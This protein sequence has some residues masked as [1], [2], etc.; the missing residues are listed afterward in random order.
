MV[1]A[2]LGHAGPQPKVNAISYA[3][4]YAFQANSTLSLAAPHQIALFPRLSTYRHATE[5]LQDR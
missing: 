3:L 1:K 2:D 5:A 4:L